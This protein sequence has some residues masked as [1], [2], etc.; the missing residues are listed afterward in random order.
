MMV[1]EWVIR[2]SYFG[3]IRELPTFN[4][5]IKQFVDDVIY[6]HPNFE[7]LLKHLSDLY[8]LVASIASDDMIRDGEKSWRDLMKPEEYDVLKENN[9]MVVG[10]MMITEKDEK[11][12][13]IELFDTVVRG[14]NLGAFMM[15]KYEK[16]K[17]V[18]PV[19][20][21]IIPTAAK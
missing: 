17:G 2:D 11:T 10:Y 1:V 3:R 20:K 4:T 5:T 16:I 21:E 15:S 6:N 7:I 9:C 13:F 14:N 12:H 8:V 18:V 19:P